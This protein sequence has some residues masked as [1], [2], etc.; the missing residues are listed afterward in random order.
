V[1][2]GKLQNNYARPGGQNVGNILSDRPS[3]R[4]LAAPGGKSQIVFG[5][6]DDASKASPRPRHSP[7][8]LPV[9][10]GLEHRSPAVLELWQVSRCHRFATTTSRLNPA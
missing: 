3:S 1:A 7:R 6:A 5:D 2:A 9:C 10:V 4:V 8:A